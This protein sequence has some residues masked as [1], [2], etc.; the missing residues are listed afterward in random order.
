LTD[1]GQVA[2]KQ[3]ASLGPHVAARCPSDVKTTAERI[4]WA[5][6]F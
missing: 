2:P 4:L 6:T 1:F 5:A 3:H